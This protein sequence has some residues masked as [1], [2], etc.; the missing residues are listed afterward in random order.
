MPPRGRSPGRPKL[1]N[2]PPRSGSVREGR[3]PSLPGN[4]ADGHPPF[5]DAFPI[6]GGGFHSVHPIAR[7][8]LLASTAGDNWQQLRP[9]KVLCRTEWRSKL[10]PIVSMA[11]ESEGAIA[12]ASTRSAPDL[13]NKRQRWRAHGPLRTLRHYGTSHHIHTLPKYTAVTKNPLISM[14]YHHLFH[15][16]QNRI[17]S[18]S[19]NILLLYSYCQNTKN[20][21]DS[22]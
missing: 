6:F 19:L 9:P 22:S 13:T 3:W 2:P 21:A 11:V 7:R 12:R 17:T 1:F 8:E 10:G 14:G 15:S 20:I 4:P 18:Y 16:Y 5:S